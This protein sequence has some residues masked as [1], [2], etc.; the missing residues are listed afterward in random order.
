MLAYD[1][2]GRNMAQL[3]IED[4]NKAGGLL[5]QPIKTILADTKSDRVEGARAGQSVVDQGANIVIVSCDYDQGSPAAGAGV[6]M[7]LACMSASTLL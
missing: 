2:D 7:A 6:I 3:W 1:G 5:G 4:R